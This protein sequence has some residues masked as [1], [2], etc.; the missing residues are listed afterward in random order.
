M[1]L[2]YRFADLLDFSLE[3]VP[4]MI[5]KVDSRENC[6]GEVHSQDTDTESNVNAMGIVS[7][8]CLFYLIVPN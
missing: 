5:E 7:I 1:K 8:L 4:P 3:T 2:F 6:E